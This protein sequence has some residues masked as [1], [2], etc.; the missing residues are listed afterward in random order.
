MKCE[1]TFSNKRSRSLKTNYIR[2]NS[3]IFIEM[4]MKARGTMAILFMSAIAF[5]FFFIIGYYLHWS[6]ILIVVLSLGGLFIQYLL[7][8]IIIGWVY[9]IDWVDLDAF[10]ISH[11]HL[12][13]FIDSIAAK[14]N[15]KTPRFGI[16][17]DGNP[18]AFCYG[19]TKNSAR[20][21][22]TDGILELLDKE[23]QK[24]VVGHELGHIVHNDFVVM[25]FVSAIPI[26]FY[27]ISQILFRVRVS[28]DSDN[29]G[30]EAG[31]M[32]LA[33][34]AYLFYIVG[35]LASLFISRVREYYA[36]EF[37]AEETG[38]PNALSSALVKIA[39]GLLP[40]EEPN[41]QRG[42]RAASQQNRSVLSTAVRSVR[43]LG[44]FDPG[45][46]NAFISTSID[47]SNRISNDRIVRAAAWDLHNPWA[48]YY[49]L[50]STHPLPAKRIKELSYYG[51]VKLKVPPTINLSPTEEV[52]KQQVGGSSLWGHF[53][54]DILMQLLPKILFYGSLI[55]GISL[56]VISYFTDYQDTVRIFKIIG[57][58]FFLAGLGQMIQ[59]SMKY[60]SKFIKQNVD[61]LIGNVKVSPIRP[62]P[63]IIDG[64]IIGRGIP[65]LFYSEDLMLRDDHGI[66][67]I[68]YNFGISIVNFLFAI[69]KTGKL[70]GHNIRVYGWFRRGP[71][72]YIQIKRIEDL[73]TGKTYRNYLDVF[74]KFLAF[75][76]MIIGAIILVFAFGVLDFSQIISV[77]F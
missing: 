59:N 5:T 43:G 63:A 8:P 47:K 76:L 18:N 24:A 52:V 72:A 57:V 44:I 77:V 60:N 31:R 13:G 61:D 74:N 26:V 37:S 66:V 49:E 40:V 19:W 30:V 9:R 55:F 39:Y 68:D 65:G 15:I 45:S 53:F 22:I 21:I 3:L 67:L 51:Y 50:F 2:N 34:L 48:R 10:N 38:N 1:P 32:A 4:G 27:T 33:A 29:A 28:S 56:L 35:Y 12:V 41:A 6:W 46:A 62:Q 42:N 7:S 36:D 71:G 23:E 54:M 58:A 25:T 16:I 69:L 64:K 70:I 75:I 11:P 14:Y 73:D 20:L 17:H